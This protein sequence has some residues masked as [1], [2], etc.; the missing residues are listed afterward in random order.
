MSVEASVLADRAEAADPLL[1]VLQQILQH[2][3]I[4]KS[5]EALLAGLPVDGR[6]TPELF[7]REAQAAGC[8]ASWVRR[9]LSEIPDLVL[10][11]VLELSDGAAAL[12]VA[13]GPDGRLAI[14]V[15]ETG[16]SRQWVD[17]DDLE[18]RYSGR[19]FFVRPR[20][21]KRASLGVRSE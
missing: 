14:C 19:C 11:V 1:G 18:A 12:L 8:N 20:P 9:D 6:V 15:P 10:P 21:A 2:H 17:A 16:D 5:R 3:G 7:V 4:R 13:R